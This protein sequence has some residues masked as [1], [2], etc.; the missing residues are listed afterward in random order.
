MLE[1]TWICGR[2]RRSQFEPQVIRVTPEDV[3]RLQERVLELLL[4]TQSVAVSAVSRSGPFSV[5]ASREMTVVWAGNT[6]PSGASKTIEEVLDR[7]MV[8]NCPSLTK[9]NF[10]SP[11]EPGY[12]VDTAAG[13]FRKVIEAATAGAAW[14]IKA[15]GSTTAVAANQVRQRG[16]LLPAFFESV[17]CRAAEPRE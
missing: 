15:S 6:V 16:R 4:K 1:A 11:C 2:K 17:F 13:L 14:A 7:S 8:S 12:K 3:P 9:E 5:L 10:K